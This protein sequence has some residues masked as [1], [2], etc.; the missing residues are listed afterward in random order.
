MKIGASRDDTI[1]KKIARC[2]VDTMQDRPIILQSLSLRENCELKERRRCNR[3][4]N[5][6]ALS[7]NPIKR[8]HQRT[9]RDVSASLPSLMSQNFPYVRL[10]RR[11]VRGSDDPPRTWP[12]WPVGFYRANIYWPFMRVPSLGKGLD[13]VTQVS[14]T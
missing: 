4:L 3:P 9:I 12:L 2:V 8:A 6:R 14:L 11:R 10:R 13:S 1:R 7:S 5:R